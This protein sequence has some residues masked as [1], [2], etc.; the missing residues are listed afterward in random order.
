MEIDRIKTVARLLK[1]MSRDKEKFS[2][3]ERQVLEDGSKLCKTK[4]VVKP[5][6]WVV[7]DGLGG[8][9]SYFHSLEKAVAWWGN[10][11]ALFPIYR[12]EEI[13]VEQAE[14]ILGREIVG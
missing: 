1:E 6:K 8:G 14:E 13:T 3:G 9:A 10:G 4:E 2:V 5:W 11:D 7:V 12:G